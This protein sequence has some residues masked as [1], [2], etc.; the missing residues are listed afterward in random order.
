MPANPATADLRERLEG[1]VHYRHE[2]VRGDE[3]GE[4]QIFLDRL[5]IALGHGGAREAG[6]VLEERIHRND[7]G[8]TAFADLVWKP[9]VLIEMK[10]AGVDLSRHYRQAF[11]YWMRLVPDRPR[12]VVLCNFDEFWIYDLNV[13]IEDPLDKILI[14]DLPR[15]WEALAFM[16]PVEQRTVFRNDQVAVTRD[17]AATVSHV[18][19]RL[20]ERGVD[21]QDAQRFILQ[22]VMAMFAE[23]I[24]MLPRHHFGLAVQD[25]LEGA[26]AFDLLF[27]LFREMNLPGATA[28]GRFEGTPYFNGGL[29]QEVTPFDINQAEIE[30]LSAAATFDWSQVRPAIFGTLFEQS[31]EKEERHAYGAHFTSEVDIQKIV[32]PS[33]VRPWQE[34]IDAASTIAE[35]RAIEHDLLQ[36]RVLDPACGCGNFL[37]IAYRELRR[38]EHQLQEKVVSRQRAAG[39]EDVMALAFVSTTQFFGL[40]IRPFAVAIAKVTLMLARKLAA[41]ELGDERTVL[42]L[43]DLDDNILTGDSLVMD[44]PAFDVCVGN[45]PYLGRN[46]IAPARGAEY[47]SWLLEK[48]PDVEGRSDYVSYFFRK[49]HDLLDPGQRAGLVGTDAVKHGYTR[50]ASLDYIVENGGVIYDAVA[51]QPWSGDAAVNVSIVNWVKNAD[52][53]PRVLWLS[54]GNVKIELKEI[55]PS[56]SPEIDVADAEQITVNR[57]PKRC[58]QG[59]TPGVTRGGRGFVITQS[60]AED[61]V[62]RDPRSAEVIYPF[63]GGRELDTDGQPK[64]FIVDIPSAD[65]LEAARWPGV[66]LIRPRQ[67]SPRERTKGQR[68]GSRQRAH[69][70]CPPG[71]RN[72]QSSHRLLPA[73]VATLVPSGGHA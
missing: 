59:Q 50:R 46:R 26:S 52:V 17:A 29:F 21:R 28:G 13:Q 10:R 42:P 44:W 33:I 39:A 55:P 6:A 16:L 62:E 5:F 19:N 18:F 15:R 61:I 48:F 63:L 12:Y 65:V 20:I 7:V 45:P 43:D 41:D 47:A 57:G 54:N 14:D 68:A 8:G 66:S 24:G 37:Y 23:D 51:S 25:C 9:R 60:V 64:R 1:F 67:H 56:L 3:K 38:L 70:R 32:L 2:H 34:R 71:A 36:Y 27:G 72:S 11:D 31:L 35:L 53:Q 22:A 49:A 73:M 69:Q 40:D 4:A 30:S 58:F